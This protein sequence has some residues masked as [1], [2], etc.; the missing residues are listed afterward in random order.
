MSCAKLRGMRSPL[1]NWSPVQL[2]WTIGIS[3]AAISLT[4]VVLAALSWHQRLPITAKRYA[5]ATI[6]IGMIVDLMAESTLQKGARLGRWSDS[7]LSAPRKFLEHPAV[8][9]SIWSMFLASLVYLILAPLRNTAIATIFLALPLSFARVGNC[10][11]PQGETHEGS[12]LALDPARPLHSDY[13]GA[14]SH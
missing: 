9:F 10:L 6:A 7:L 12:D 3:S 8:T 4:M 5:V 11:R 14:S 13:W 1:R 2:I